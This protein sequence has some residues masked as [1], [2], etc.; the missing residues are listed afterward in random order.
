MRRR[1]RR[2]NRALIP[3]GYDGAAIAKRSSK[4][5]HRRQFLSAA[6]AAV[7]GANGLAAPDGPDPEATAT[8]AQQPASEKP[9]LRAGEDAAPAE[10]RRVRVILP[11]PY[12]KPR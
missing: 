9:E 7:I 12:A 10:K 3:V 11:S 5:M 8:T 4:A 2:A 6:L 1:A